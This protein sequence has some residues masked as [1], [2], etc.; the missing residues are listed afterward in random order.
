MQPRC[1]RIAPLRIRVSFPVDDC[2]QNRAIE[3]WTGV[4]SE[5]H[6]RACTRGILLAIPS[7]ARTRPSL[8]NVLLVQHELL[9]P[10]F[11]PR[12]LSRRLL[13]LCCTAAA[14][15]AA[16]AGVSLYNRVYGRGLFT[17]LQSVHLL[18]DEGLLRRNMMEAHTYLKLLD[19]TNL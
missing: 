4:Y 8:C 3:E 16:A 13:L 11:S 1:A 12:L 10:D 18:N 14:A 6:V 2:F 5:R 7:R 15:A 19:P 9:Q 17:S